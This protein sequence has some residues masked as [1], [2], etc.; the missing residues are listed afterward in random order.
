MWVATKN[1]DRIAKIS[2]K[3]ERSNSF[4]HHEFLLSNWFIIN[5]QAFAF[6][7]AFRVRIRSYRKCRKKTTI[8]AVFNT[9][10]WL[11][12]N[13][14]C[15]IGR[16]RMRITNI[17]PHTDRMD[18]WSQESKWEEIVWSAVSKKINR[19]K[20]N[21]VFMSILFKYN[22]LARFFF[23]KKNERKNKISRQDVPARDWKPVLIFFWFAP[24]LVAENC[25]GLW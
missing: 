8:L 15:S 20:I 7:F 21:F 10:C 22:L 24:S 18:T 13:C 6:A 11:G 4:E 2:I 5:R 14:Y 23:E 19:K 25:H 12:D 9:I 17:V 1:I 3:L 16:L